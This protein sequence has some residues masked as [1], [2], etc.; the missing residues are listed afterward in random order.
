MEI[1]SRLQRGRIVKANFPDSK[2]KATHPH[3]AVILTSAE[4][5]AKGQPIVVVGISSRRDLCPHDLQ[6]WLPSTQKRGGHHLT[7]LT[8]PCAAMCNWFQK[9]NLGDIL[10][11][12]GVAPAYA[13]TQ[14][15]NKAHQQGLTLSPPPTT[16]PVASPP[17]TSPPSIPPP[18]AS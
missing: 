18:S 10:E 11:I 4:D 14:I 6:V 8:Q 13:I 15:E 7:Q 17:A 16:A 9:I 2:G 5:I 1:D 3:P 12:K